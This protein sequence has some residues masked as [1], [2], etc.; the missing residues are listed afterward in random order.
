MY[1]FPQIDWGTLRNY[2]R[3][4]VSDVMKETDIE[5]MIICGPDNIRYATDVGVF[6]ICEAYDWYA[7][8]V[9]KNG[10]AYIFLPYVD[11]V[12]KNPLPELYAV[13]K[14][15]PKAILAVLTPT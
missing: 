6:L 14:V 1:E 4:I 7:S 9:T 11:T 2:R 15:A 13:G 5:A 8:I 12:I 10:D 3:N